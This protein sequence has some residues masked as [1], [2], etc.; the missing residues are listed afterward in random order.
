ME[1]TNFKKWGWWAIG[2]LVAVAI[3]AALVVAMGGGP[4]PTESEEP[5][6][7]V[8]QTEV[9]NNG[10]WDDDEPED[11]T[12]VVAVEEVGALPQTGPTEDG[13]LVLLLAGV[14]AYVMSLMLSSVFRAAR[15]EKKA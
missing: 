12:S 8:E 13:M 5:V 3:V 1:K 9:V 4:K 2:G 7:N 11:E 6:E 15:L 14:F 10:N